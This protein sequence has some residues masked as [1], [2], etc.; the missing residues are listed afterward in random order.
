MEEA[1]ITIAS[2]LAVAVGAMYG[3]SR[4]MVKS[5]DKKMN[6]NPHNLNGNNCKELRRDFDNQVDACTERFMEIS[7][8]SGTTAEAIVNIKD[9][10]ERIE[11]KLDRG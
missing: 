11:G 9:S 3:M 8:E 4:L 7:R 2:T 6:G 5:L 10:L 1:I